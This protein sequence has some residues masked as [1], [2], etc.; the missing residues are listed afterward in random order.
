MTCHYFWC[1]NPVTRYIIYTQQE[2]YRAIC[3]DCY[4]H[5]MSFKHTDLY[6]TISEQEYFEH[7]L[8]ESL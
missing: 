7:V 4:I 8:Q 2:E 3:E 5:H 6:R 1:L